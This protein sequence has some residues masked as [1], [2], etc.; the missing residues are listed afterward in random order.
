MEIPQSIFLFSENNASNTIY[1]KEYSGY[2]PTIPL[3][4]LVT[5]PPGN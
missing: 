4:G 5:L 1:F 2:D 3:E